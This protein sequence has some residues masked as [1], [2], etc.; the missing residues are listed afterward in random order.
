MIMD[1]QQY[2]STKKALELAERAL[3]AL[4]KDLLPERQEEYETFSEAYIDYV[5]RL[6]YEIDE[7]LGL[8]AAEESAMPLWVR[9]QGPQISDRAPMS[10]L[11]GFLRD[12]RYGVYQVSKYNMMKSRGPER[13]L[14][15]S[16]LRRLTNAKVKVMPGSLRIGVSLPLGQM[17]IDGKTIDDLP[18][19][20]IRKV[21]VGA[22]WSANPETRKIEEILPDPIER[23]LVLSHVERLSSMRGGEVS[24]IEFRGKLLK[25]R[26]FALTKESVEIVKKARMKELPGE[27]MTLEG[28]IREIDLDGRHFS[29]RIVSSSGEEERRQ[30]VYDP[31]F[32]EDVKSRLDKR[33]KIIGE[34]HPVAV[35]K[36]SIK[37]KMIEQ[38]ESE[39]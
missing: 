12:L 38:M 24:S 17:L 16:E 3:K 10:V 14:Q 13:R 35:G 8:H 29:L 23:Q 9:L 2:E 34:A 1:E 18:G 19:D 28:I 37:L 4:Q 7:Y 15:D 27:M 36:P 30:C 21:L 11:S 6:R 32:E 25:D 26:G 31:V 22:S 20:A 39:D 5:Y 33:V